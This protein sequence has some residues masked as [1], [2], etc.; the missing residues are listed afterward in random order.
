MHFKNIHGER[1]MPKYHE[2]NEL[3]PRDIVS[4]SIFSE[5]KKTKSDHVYL[6]ITLKEGITWSIGFLTFINLYELWN[7][8]V[9]GLYSMA[10]AE[11]YCM[12]GIRTDV[13]GR[14]NIKGFFACGETACNGIHG[15]N[16]LA[17]TFW[18]AWYSGIKLVRKLTAL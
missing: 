7:R 12:G 11:H 13:W 10:P 9:K 14:T 4:R 17:S 16:R 1:F 18:K 3:A 8:Y 15:A 5:M 2:L 6:D